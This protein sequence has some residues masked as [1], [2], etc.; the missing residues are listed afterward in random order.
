MV[1]YQHKTHPR[2]RSLRITINQR[3]EV[4]V[5]TPRFTPKIVVELFVRQQQGWITK[6]LAKIKTL[7]PATDSHQLQLFG[8]NYHIVEIADGRRGRGVHLDPEHHQLLINH[9]ALPPATKNLSSSGQTML[10]RYLKQTAEKYLFPRTK[11]W[12]TTMGLTFHKLT[13]REQKT[14]WGSCSSQGDISFNWRLV[15]HPPEVIDY[16]IIHELAHRVQ[17][18]HSAAFWNVVKKYDPAFAEHKGWLKRRGYA[19]S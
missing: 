9:V 15:H 7:A 6:Q 16:V 10:T 19:L 13:L 14:R 2:A 4:V 17:M 8:Q 5:T 3:G 18:N 12:A 11:Q 1:S